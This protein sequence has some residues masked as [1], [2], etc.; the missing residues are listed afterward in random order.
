MPNHPPLRSADF[1]ALSEFRFQLARFLRFADR[2]AK[3][4]GMTPL[5]YLLLLHVKGYP[6][7]SCA[8][9]GEVAERLQKSHHSVVALVQR[10]ESAGLVQRRQSDSDRRKVQVRLTPKGERKVLKVATLN[11]GELHSLARVFRVA[12]I[13]A[14]NDRDEIS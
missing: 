12:R 7:A 6:G 13:S 1:E 8:S 14:F 3:S 2:S 4:Q 5:Q 11:R 9:I 10:C